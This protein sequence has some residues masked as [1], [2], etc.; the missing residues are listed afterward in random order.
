MR[1]QTRL[2]T[3][4]LLAAAPAWPQTTSREWPVY[5]GN[6]EGT[7]YSP[8]KQID[9]SNV[10]RLAGGMEV[11]HRPVGRAG[12]ARPTPIVVD[13]VLYA[14]TPARQVIALDAATESALEVGVRTS[15]I[16]R[17]AA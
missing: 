17:G 8:L 14:Y 10:A 16:R 2:L 1:F 3:A 7:R 9:R 13:G 12:S 6:T 5:G 11:R 15:G 4:T